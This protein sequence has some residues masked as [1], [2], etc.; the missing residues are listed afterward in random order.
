MSGPARKPLFALSLKVMV[1]R[2]PGMRAPERSMTKEVANIVIKTHM[3]L[4]QLL[5]VVIP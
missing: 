4:F 1:K 2:G 3:V 5:Q